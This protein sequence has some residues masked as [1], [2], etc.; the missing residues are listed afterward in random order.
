M[1]VFSFRWLSVDFRHFQVF[2]FCHRA[3]FEN[4]ETMENFQ[5]LLFGGYKAI[6]PILRIFLG[7]F[8]YVQ[9]TTLKVLLKVINEHLLLFL[10]S[11]F[12]AY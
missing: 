5:K 2:I 11:G 8:L 6:Y 3:I 9:N 12:V 7:I 4:P 10:E 1:S